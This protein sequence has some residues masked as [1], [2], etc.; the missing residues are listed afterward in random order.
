MAIVGGSGFIGTRLA[1]RLISEGCTVRI[2]DKRSSTEY[3]D[4]W[5]RADVRDEESLKTALKDCTAIFDLAAVHRDN[6]RPRSL[7]YDTNTEGACNICRAAEE[8]GIEKILF[9][10]TVAVYGVTDGETDEEAVRRPNND[11]G[12]SK[13]EAEDIY[14][15]WRRHG[16]NRG[17]TIVRPTVVF[18][19]HNRGNLYNLMNQIHR[20]S[21]IMIGKGISIKSIAYVENVASF[22]A[23]HL[24]FGP[25]E[26]MVNYA[27]KPD[28][29]MNQ[30]VTAIYGLLGKEPRIPIRLPY[31]F[32]ILGGIVFDALSVMTG[33]EYS[34][35][36][37]R[38]KKFCASTQFSSSSIKRTGFIPPFSLSE[39]L[40]RTVRH[41]FLS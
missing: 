1:N 33:K 31:S 15:E 38:V 37:R 3:P 26:R 35:S 20:G 29:D 34:I 7:Y 32:G 27:D 17:L 21:F 12:K 13:K 39:G 41:E 25:G 22:L 9:T 11:Y 8:N 23:F 24:Q 40:E 6:V 18:G 16:N 10:S 5:V 28:F 36:T 4:F 2:V 14:L 19:E 30:L